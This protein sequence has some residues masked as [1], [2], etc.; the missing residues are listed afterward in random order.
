MPIE[1]PGRPN[2]VLIVT[3]NQSADSLG[4]YGNVE[5]ETP[6]LDRLAREGMR[7]LSA[8]TTNGTCSPAR[9]RS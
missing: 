5:H 9:A 4:C 2:V 1:D 7:F 3:D 8:F 6:H